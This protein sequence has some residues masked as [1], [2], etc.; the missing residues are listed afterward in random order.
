MIL[1]LATVP[2]NTQEN[3]QSQETNSFP[4]L[5]AGKDTTPAQCFQPS[6]YYHREKSD[7]QSHHS[8]ATLDRNSAHEQASQKKHLSIHHKNKFTSTCLIYYIKQ[9]RKAL[10]H[11]AEKWQPAGK[12]WLSN[13]NSAK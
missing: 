3:E 8:W 4:C 12:K 5:V 6:S 10:R 1:Q 13:T 9:D 11:A 2:R 7:V